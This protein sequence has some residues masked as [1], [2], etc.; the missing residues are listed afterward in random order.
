[1]EGV[2]EWEGPG[3]AR[4]RPRAGLLGAPPPSPPSPEPAPREEGCVVHERSAPVT[5]IYAPFYHKLDEFVPLN[6]DENLIINRVGA[7]PPSPPS[8]EPTLQDTIV[9]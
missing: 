7:L 8:P 3:G 6:Q 2:E 5:I 9:I 1:M 4:S